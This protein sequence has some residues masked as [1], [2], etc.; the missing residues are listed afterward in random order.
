MREERSTLLNSQD[1]LQGS[2]NYLMK[3]PSSSQRITHPVAIHLK[4]HRC[5]T[6]LVTVHTS[7]E[8]VNGPQAELAGR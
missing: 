7:P 8:Q 5:E 2:Q 1:C 3:E 6:I 4:V